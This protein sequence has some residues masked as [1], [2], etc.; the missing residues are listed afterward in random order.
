M[1]SHPIRSPHATALLNS[2]QFQGKSND[3]GPFTIA[4]VLNALRNLEIQAPELASLMDRPAWR[5]PHLVIRRLPNWATFPWGIVD[6][7]RSYG[8]S[9]KWKMFVK[10]IQM[11]E[12]L[13]R[14]WI[15]M[16]VIGSWRP[17]W[18]HVMTCISWHP[19]TGY[20]F[21]NTQ[22]NKQDIYWLD[23]KTFARQWRA[24]GG[25]LITVTP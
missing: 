6:I 23:E 17:L 18:A 11:L 25:I 4:T 24:M 10:P 8:L 9:A 5:G 19:D 2:L 16:P 21:A 15:V 7:F 3:C 22:I 12:K 20:G 13:D 1:F 14:G